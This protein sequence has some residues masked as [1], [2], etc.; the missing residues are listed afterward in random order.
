[1]A[2][3]DKSSAYIS[4]TDNIEYVITVQDTMFGFGLTFNTVFKLGVNFL[5]KKKKKKMP[6]LRF[7]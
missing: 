2:C 5:K 3:C 6:F 4:T 7:Q 1:M